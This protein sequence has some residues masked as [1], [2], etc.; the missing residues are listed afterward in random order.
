MTARLALRLTVD[1][2]G[3]A[4]CVDCAELLFDLRGWLTDLL[5][6]PRLPAAVEAGLARL[7][8]RLSF[9]PVALMPLAAGV[10]LAA[11]IALLSQRPWLTEP[12]LVV[13]L[14]SS[15]TFLFLHQSGRDTADSVLV[16]MLLGLSL[17]YFDGDSARR[18]VVCWFLSLLA[19]AGYVIPGVTKAGSGAWRSGRAL[20]LLFE[21]QWLGR[22]GIARLM[23]RH[24][25]VPLALAWS[26][27]GFELSFPLAIV[28]PRPVAVLVLVA[29]VAFH[30]GIA[31]VM[32][33]NDFLWVFVATYPSV[34]ACNRAL[35]PIG[36]C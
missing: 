25:R 33:L 17:A 12:A 29:G 22:R 34:L 27:I 1:L 13:A 18:L 20:L 11:A 35:H 32:G 23:Q 19:C 6:S 15:A 14:V 31:V 24:P 10:R 26:V 16:L 8:P 36:Q 2:V 5:R 3:V 30:A 4:L 7:G 28:A 9:L 21:T